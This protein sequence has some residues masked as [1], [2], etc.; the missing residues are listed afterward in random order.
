MLEEGKHEGIW[1]AI[2]E[3]YFEVPFQENSD[4]QAGI[5]ECDTDTDADTDTWWTLFLKKGSSITAFQ[6]MMSTV[7]DDGLED[8]IKTNHGWHGTFVVDKRMWRK[9][10]K[11]VSGILGDVHRWLSSIREGSGLLFAGKTIG[12]DVG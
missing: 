10:V 2:E 6:N 7:T 12:I 11:S 5:Q 3:V 8:S 4:I 9:D 1:M